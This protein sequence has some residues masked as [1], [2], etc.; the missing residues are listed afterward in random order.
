MTPNYLVTLSHKPFPAVPDHNTSKQPGRHLVKETFQTDIQ[1]PMR[2][3]II[4]ILADFN[5]TG[6]MNAF[7]Q[8]ICIIYMIRRD[9]QKMMPAQSMQ[10]IEPKD[11]P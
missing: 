7:P 4:R 9:F 1:K 3:N 10:D 11:G 2:T 6:I 8:D 5:Y